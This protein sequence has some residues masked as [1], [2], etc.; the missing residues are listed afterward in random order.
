MNELFAFDPDSLETVIVVL[1]KLGIGALLAGMVG[2]EREF[3]GRP[4]GIRTH[5]LVGIGTILF[6]ECSK[7]FNEGD[8]GRVAAQVVTGI[9]FLGAGTIMR[10]G[11]EVKGLTTAASIWAVAALGMCVSIGG[12]FMLVAMAGTALTLITLVVVD[13]ME[14]YIMPQSDDRELR[15]ILNEKADIAPVLSAL[16]DAGVPLSEIQIRQTSPTVELIAHVTH[17]HD[18]V[19]AA[20]SALSSVAAASWL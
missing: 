18:K 2:Y 13:R 19:L 12:P 10:T 14:K 15:V 5:M 3:H 1:I 17:G 9:G 6:V 4:A 7:A 11:L 8:P 16:T 20:V